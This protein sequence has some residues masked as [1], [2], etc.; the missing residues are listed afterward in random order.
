MLEALIFGYI[1]KYLGD[2]LTCALSKEVGSPNSYHFFSHRP[3]NRS[4]VPSANT[5]L[6]LERASDP[7]K[8]SLLLWW[9]V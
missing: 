8:I 2:I 4:V 1:H 5:C 3:L 6:W 9:F 7:I